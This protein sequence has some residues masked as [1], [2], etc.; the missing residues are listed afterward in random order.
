MR[1]IDAYLGYGLGGLGVLVAGGSMVVQVAM[2]VQGDLL[3]GI[4]MVLGLATGVVL[5]VAGYRWSREATS[6]ADG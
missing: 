3:G 2:I 1:E 4:A 6:R 5:Y